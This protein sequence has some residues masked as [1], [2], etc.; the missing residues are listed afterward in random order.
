MILT[1]SKLTDRKK[2]RV[3]VTSFCIGGQDFLLFLEPFDILENAVFNGT[4]RK[5]V[6]KVKIPEP[7]SKMM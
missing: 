4:F 1:F 3:S 6:Q 2:K 5:M 7:L